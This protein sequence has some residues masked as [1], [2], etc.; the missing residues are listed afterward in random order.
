MSNKN[1]Q[2]RKISSGKDNNNG[3]EDIMHEEV[4]DLF[5]VNIPVIYLDKK[6]KIEWVGSFFFLHETV[7]PAYFDVSDVPLHSVRH[8]ICRI[9]DGQ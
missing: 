3:K 6:Y 5:L 8:N 9:G 1:K 7:N 4:T 2:V